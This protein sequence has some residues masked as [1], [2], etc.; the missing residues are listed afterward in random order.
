MSFWTHFPWAFVVAVSATPSVAYEP[1]PDLRSAIAKTT[2]TELLA[3]TPRKYRFSMRVG[4]AG[5][6]PFRDYERLAKSNGY[7]PY[8]DC[9][10]ATLVEVTS[11]QVATGDAASPEA[12]A[13]LV[14]RCQAAQATLL[15]AKPLEQSIGD[16]E[17]VHAMWL[18][19]MDFMV[20]AMPDRTLAEAARTAA[21]QR[22][23]ALRGA[24][25]G[26]HLTRRGFEAVT[27]VRSESTA[28]RDNETRTPSAPTSAPSAPPSAPPLAPVGGRAA[29]ASR[30]VLRTVTRYGLSGVYVTNATYQ[31]FDDGSIMSAPRDDPA[32]VDLA[33]L[34]RSRAKDFGRW[35]ARGRELAVTWPGKS[36]ATWKTWFTLRPASAGQTLAGRF[37]AVDGFGG[38]EVINFDT[39]ALTRDGRYAWKTT[40]GGTTSWLPAYS[41]SRHAGRYQ[42][43]GHGIRLR[44]NEGNEQRHLFAF[45]PRDNAH[46]VI[47]AAHFAAQK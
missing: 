37:Q 42:L 30:L 5:N 26:W 36:P 29:D 40:K 46:F 38:S 24:L 3:K 43:D 7:P 47:G 33:T 27:H 28:G 6:T 12:V 32:T 17:I 9:S 8:D 4:L 15:G 21:T 20:R 18:R 16:G 10:V 41:H 11:W 2:R 31:L 19:N 25:D 35:R 39:I 1:D 22:F 14:K 23:E 44:S 45:Y 34:R 13:A